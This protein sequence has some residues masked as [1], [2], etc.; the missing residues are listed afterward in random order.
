MLERSDDPS[1]MNP[2]AP[3]TVDVDAGVL[4][5]GID[6]DAPL[7][8]RGA[9]LAAAFLDGI[10]YGVGLVPL[11]LFVQGVVIRSGILLVVCGLL[12]LAVS[13]VQYHGIVTRGQTLAKRWLSIKIV[14]IDG[15]RVG[16]LD[17]VVLRAWLPF[18]MGLIPVLG[19]F[20]GLADALAIFGQ[21]RMCLHD[22]IAK[23]KVV[24]A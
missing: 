16:F 20:F 5:P 2:Y 6:I 17:G 12:F 8:T 3:P 11:S 24:L 10:L 13:M 1:A 21:D 18:L 22:R 9:R 14:K 19:S 15:S 4:A 23:T 7:A